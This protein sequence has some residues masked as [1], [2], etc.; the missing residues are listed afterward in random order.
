MITAAPR[1]QSIDAV[2]MLPLLEQR[3]TAPRNREHI[4]I[5]AYRMLTGCHPAD[6]CIDDDFSF[7]R[8]VLASI[9]A[10]A[11]M[12]NGAVT[13]RAG[14]AATTLPVSWRN[15]FRRPAAWAS[16]GARKDAV[17]DDDEIAMVRDLLLAQRSSEGDIGRWLAAMIARRCDGAEP[18]VG[19][20]RLAR[21][22]RT[23]PAAG[24]PFRSARRAQHQEYAVEAIL[25]S[26]ALR[27][28][29]AS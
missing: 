12:E 20:P 25:L 11:A 4:G 13:E 19:R 24:A 26:H 1:E 27:G 9:L 16:R 3:P 23:D 18:S 29:T 17:A 8:H 28:S 2:T 10:V 15:G 14:L 5:A 22:L 21:P 7:D 6:A